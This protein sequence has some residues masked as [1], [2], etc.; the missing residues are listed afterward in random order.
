[1]YERNIPRTDTGVQEVKVEQPDYI[2]MMFREL[3][4]K[5]HVFCPMCEI[6][7][8]NNSFCQAPAMEGY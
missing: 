6:W 7:H 5:E 3:L 4:G 1:M 8:A 2:G